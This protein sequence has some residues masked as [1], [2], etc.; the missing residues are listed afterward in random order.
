[1]AKKAVKSENSVKVEETKTEKTLNETEVVN[2]T[3]TAESATVESINQTQE[4]TQEDQNVRSSYDIKDLE[5]KYVFMDSTIKALDIAYDTAKNLILFGKGGHGK[6]E[7]TEDFLRLKGHIPYV[8]TMG[9]GMN[10]D[11]LFGGFDLARFNEEGVVHYLVENS[12]MAH[13]IVIFEELFDAPDFILEQLKDI[14]SSGIFRMGDQM[15]EIKTKLIICC[16][17]KKREDFA[18]D[19]SLRA[20]MERF[21]LEHE[22]KWNAYTRMNYDKLFE[23][24]F[25]V[26]NNLLSF[27][28]EEF[29]KG[30]G[31]SSKK[32]QISPRIALTAYE[33]VARCG[34]TDC[35]EYIA[36]FRSNK[37]L[38]KDALK[39]FKSIGE[40]MKIKEE[41]DS[42]FNPEIAKA[43][44]GIENDEDFD[45]E[46]AKEMG[47]MLNRCE[48]LLNKVDKLKAADEIVSEKSAIKKQLEEKKKS[49]SNIVNALKNLGV[50]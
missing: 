43:L 28:L 38:L 16:T 19:D 6:S 25:G 7:I 48:S 41:I 35:L 17:N 3:S 37:N 5:E 9:S 39:K 42:K 40:L 12:F 15:Y 36:E 13:E 34:D 46:K 11:R 24:R 29:A 1:M 26:T 44:E 8:I 14:L 2:E 10:L 22:V 49:F 31:N 30:G 33:I 50:L 27:I 20:L 32:V 18:K 45:K 47:K 23:K 4:E 21:P